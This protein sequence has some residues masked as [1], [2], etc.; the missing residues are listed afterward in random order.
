MS[1]IDEKA[2][3]LLEYMGF[4]DMEIYDNQHDNIINLLTDEKLI[5]KILENILPLKTPYFTALPSLLYNDE[6]RKSLQ[7]HLSET[8]KDIAD[9]CYLTSEEYKIT[10]LKQERILSNKYHK[11]GFLDLSCVFYEYYKYD[12]YTIGKQELEKEFDAEAGYRRGLFFE[13]KTKT[14]TI[15]SITREIE[16]YQDCIRK[17]GIFS[18]ESKITILGIVVAPGKITSKTNQFYS[19]SYN[20]IL[21][22]AKQCG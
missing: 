7:I 1:K 15:G 16:F 5:I 12:L 11:Y 9:F 18:Y 3:T 10:N 19:Y 14:P 13:V 8:R 6:L 4:K 22:L 20:E 17:L 2:K 21:E